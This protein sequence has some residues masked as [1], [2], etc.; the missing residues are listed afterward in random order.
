MYKGG[1]EMFETIGD[2]LS[3]D[4]QQELENINFDVPDRSNGRKSYHTE[5]YSVIEYLKKLSKFNLVSFPM[6]ITK[7]EAPDF[8]I[9][10]PISSC[11]LEFTEASTEA[12][13]CAMSKQSNMEGFVLID[14]STFKKSEQVTVKQ[15]NQSFDGVGKKTLFFRKGDKM[16]GPGW[17]DDEPEV[18]WAEIIA[19]TIK[20]KTVILNKPHFNTQF[21]TE[22]LIYDNTHVSIKPSKV[23]GYLD[24]A[25]G[26]LNLNT[27][28]ILQYECISI[29]VHN[30]II[31]DLTHGGTVL[32]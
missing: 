19:D 5:R 22:L 30:K 18:E 24:K 27:K 12:F 3:I 4:N 31:Y 21:R 23:I 29:I 25:I 10:N 8:F 26:S 32:E 2:L 13:Q 16:S 1:I 15:V 17:I 7:H 9:K 11:G 6:E 20:K 28:Y 14:T